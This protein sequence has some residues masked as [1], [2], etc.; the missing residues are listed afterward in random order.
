VRGDL[1]SMF[2]KGA[3]SNHPKSIRSFSRII[4]SCSP[5]RRGRIFRR[6]SRLETL[7][8]RDEPSMR[9]KTFPSCALAFTACGQ[10]H[11]GLKMLD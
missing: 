3:R 10:T 4:R 5:V 1:L 11:F 2:R 9:K 7:G 8:C 6:L